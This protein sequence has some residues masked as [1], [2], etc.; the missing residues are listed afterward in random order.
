MKDGDGRRARI[1]AGKFRFF[2]GNAVAV[3][4]S[5]GQRRIRLPEVGDEGMWWSVKGG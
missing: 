2:R 1:G 5:L 3:A 4:F